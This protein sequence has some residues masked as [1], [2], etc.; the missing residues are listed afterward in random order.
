MNKI[1]RVK[2]KNP[3]PA[4][5][6]HYPKFRFS[7]IRE[8]GIQVQFS[9]EAALFDCLQHR[10]E[11]RVHFNLKGAKWNIISFMDEISQ[12]SRPGLLSKKAQN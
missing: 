8:I 2:E 12:R 5:T 9:F 4:H 3:D 11:L 1:Y 10:Q 7:L 6:I